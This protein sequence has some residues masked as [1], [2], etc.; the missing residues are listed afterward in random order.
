MK[1][2]YL[3]LGVIISTNVYSQQPRPIIYLIPGQG[4]DERLF[5]N[6]TIEDYT[7]K[8]I[9]YHVPE[10]NTSLKEYALQLSYQIDTTQKFALIGV[11]LGGMLATEM[12]EFLTPEKIIIISSAKSQYEL[13]FRYRFQKIVPLYKMFSSRAIKRGAT[14]MQPLVEPDRNKEKETF[15]SMLADKNK[16][17][18]KRSVQMIIKWDRKTYSKNIVHIHGDKDNTIPIKNVNYNHL[19]NGGSHMITLTRP[20]EISKIINEELNKLNL[21]N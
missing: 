3:F 13:P 7:M 11:S 18:M 4:A 8:H 14:I 9:K 16:Y 20:D 2:A 21:N 1:Y 17:F 19:I 5:G 6:L 15:K 12:N 10:K